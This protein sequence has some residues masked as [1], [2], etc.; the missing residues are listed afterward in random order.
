MDESSPESEQPSEQFD[1]QVEAQ[2]DDEDNWVEIDV[3]PAP[4]D[5]LPQGWPEVA[6]FLPASTVARQSPPELPFFAELEVAESPPAVRDWYVRQYSSRGWLVLSR[7]RRGSTHRIR[8]AT[9]QDRWMVVVRP[10]QSEDGTTVQVRQLPAGPP[11]TSLPGE[12]GAE[13][14]RAALPTTRR[15]TEVVCE[16]SEGPPIASIPLDV[17][18]VAVAA[19]SGDMGVVYRDSSGLSLIVY[20]E[21]GFTRGPVLLS[22]NVAESAHPELSWGADHGWIAS[23]IES[24]GQRR[25]LYLTSRLSR[26][27]RV[28]QLSEQL[29]SSEFGWA[30]VIVRRR[31]EFAAAWTERLDDLTTLWVA[32]IKPDGDR[33]RRSGRVL[34]TSGPPTHGPRL[35]SADGGENLAMVW[36][37]E[38]GVFL[39]TIGTD[40]LPDAPERVL[41]ASPVDWVDVG[42]GRQSFWVVWRSLSDRGFWVRTDL[43]GC[44]DDAR[45]VTDGNPIGVW[46]SPHGVVVLVV[47]DQDYG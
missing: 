4:L 30:P 38:T 27:N 46:S 29:E 19:Q 36:A 23:W 15:A 6:P 41:D 13:D 37:S 2:E 18:E 35:A 34:P 22:D 5:E 16:W 26:P 21:E 33:V 1:E 8:F 25:A 39:R 31:Q 3:E 44:V 24:D 10:S 7:D 45:G 43:E 40:G 17:E 11:L 9:A 42:F 20:T 14:C 12:L 47:R 28:L 32:G